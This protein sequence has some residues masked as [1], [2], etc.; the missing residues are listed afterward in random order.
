MTY[1]PK[2]E[3]PRWMEILSAFCSYL[4]MAGA[5]SILIFGVLNMSDVLEFNILYYITSI[6]VM[7]ISLYGVVTIPSE[8]EAEG[9]E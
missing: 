3:L 4:F 7:F 8:V 6:F 1:I 2:N 9:W 5:Y